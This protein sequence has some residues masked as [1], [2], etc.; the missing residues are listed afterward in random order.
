MIAM[1]A[2]AP[3]KI[4]FRWLR[5]FSYKW[6]KNSPLFALSPLPKALQGD[7]MIAMEV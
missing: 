6:E 3:R 2:S 5:R 7:T 1:V 4:R